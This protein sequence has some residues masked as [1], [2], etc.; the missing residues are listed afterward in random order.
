VGR[1][2]RPGV[3]V[4]SQYWI[5]ASP[6]KTSGAL[7]AAPVKPGG[8]PPRF[9]QALGIDDARLAAADATAAT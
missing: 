2:N 4:L 7:T 6:G 1:Q 8:T 5:L 9:A 3:V